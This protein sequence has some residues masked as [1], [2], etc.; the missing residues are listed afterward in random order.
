MKHETKGKEEKN[1]QAT[2]HKMKLIFNN[3]FFLSE[4]KYEKILL[5]YQSGLRG[6][7]EERE[8]LVEAHK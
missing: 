1:N 7:E 5:K 2:K 8:F 6:V 4:K 3:N